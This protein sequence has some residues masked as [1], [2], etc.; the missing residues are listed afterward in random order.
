MLNSIDISK[1]SPMMRHY[2]ELKKEYSDC[3]I[4]YRL[5]DFYE[6]FFDD[7]IKA[8]QVLQITVTGRDC[9]LDK[10]APMCGIPH[11]AAS[12]Y[13]QKLVQANLKVAICE[14]LTKPGESKGILK[15]DIVKVI[16]KGTLI[17]DELLSASISN[18]LMSIIIK[19]DNIYISWSDISQGLMFASELKLTTDNILNIFKYI[20]P[21]ETI[22][23]ELTYN[24]IKD[25]LDMNFINE[26]NISQTF[27][28]SQT[29]QK[30][31]KNIKSIF[32][33]SSLLSY[34]ISDTS[35]LVLSINYLLEYY[36]HTQKQTVVNFSKISYRNFNNYL[37]LDSYSIENLE[38]FSTKKD[39][40]KFGS[41][42]NTINKTKTAQGSRELI[43]CIKF[44]FL[45]T[46]E[47]NL[48]LD[49]IE[50]LLE[51]K[52]HI[53]EVRESLSKISDIER[54]VSKIVYKSSSPRD[55]IGLA[56]S[57]EEIEKLIYVLRD[58]ESEYIQLIL[59]NLNSHYSVYET[60]NRAIDPNAPSH[61]RN[62]GYI[63]TGYSSKL[64]ELREYSDNSFAWMAEYEAKQRELTGYK[65]LKVSYNKIF[66]YFIDIPK[67]LTKN[68]P[69]DYIRK[70]TL[71]NSERYTTSI[72]AKKESSI[73]TSA[74]LVIETEQQIY[75]S[76]IKLILENCNSLIETS[77]KIGKIDVIYNYA[78]ISS[79]F[80]YAKPKI[81]IN[82]KKIE[83]IESRHPVIEQLVE[84][85]SFIANDVY[86]DKSNNKTIILTG[87]NMSGKS[88]YM[89]QIAHITILAQMGC[90]VPAKV[91]IL[92]ITDRIFTRIGAADDLVT[93][94]STFMVEMIETANIL[95]NATSNS[96]ILLDEIGR[97]TSTYEGLSLAWSI[98]EYLTTITNS[99]TIISTHYHELTRIEGNILGVVNYRALVDESRD[100]VIFLH[101][102]EKGYS[103]KSFGIEVAQLAGVKKQITDRAKK[104]YSILTKN[105]INKQIHNILMST[106]FSDD[107]VIEKRSLFDYEDDSL[108][109][110]RIK[111]LDIDNMTNE[112]LRDFLNQ[113][114]KEFN[115]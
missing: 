9:G 102:I 114:R 2:A 59:N 109:K 10:K 96:L 72:L 71:V 98:V 55:F 110:I 53:D 14:Q 32:N 63:K 19:K 76:L 104:I 30:A 37:F 18:Y 43:E 91:A 33:I 105:D 107:V 41:L 39:S 111:N 27:I 65:K 69:D 94:K 75:D 92:A 58:T 87:P 77:T 81:D 103:E 115:D 68:I 97:G 108:L 84:E 3:I 54:I 38:L 62:G 93:N 28:K 7:A 46:S 31:L 1:L 25:N 86:L 22:T 83:L 60:I 17:E 99:K 85:N 13:I 67:S 6:M 26:H 82:N 47:I 66:G 88:T 74:N 78:Y 42:Y 80:N 5:G 35:S 50:S 40:Q 44:P 112:M 73:L 21:N 34:G 100:E 70:Q 24:Y 57:L 20:E 95:N 90:Y 48:R 23:D 113:I 49:A 79:L 61:T 52:T 56:N 45:D 101:K 11:H 106:N 12:T 64:D 15:R 36:S 4:F 29:I 51:N 16:T 8:S 89:R